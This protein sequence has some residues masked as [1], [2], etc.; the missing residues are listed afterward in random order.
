MPMHNSWLGGNLFFTTWWPDHEK[1]RFWC[2]RFMNSTKKVCCGRQDV[3]LNQFASSRLRYKLCVLRLVRE[4]VKYLVLNSIMRITTVEI[5]SYIIRKCGKHCWPT[6]SSFSWHFCIALESCSSNSS[7]LVPIPK[8][9]ST[10][11]ERKMT[12]LMQDTF[13]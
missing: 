9:F 6:S 13:C 1:K 2:C 11:N 5:I 4:W 10:R 7:D 3:N 12:V 8:I